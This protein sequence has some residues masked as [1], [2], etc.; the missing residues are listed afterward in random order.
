MERSNTKWRGG[1]RNIKLWNEGQ[2]RVCRKP[3]DKS[4]FSSRRQYCPQNMFLQVVWSYFDYLW[5]H[6]KQ[7]FPDNICLLDHEQ[8]ESS[9]KCWKIFLRSWRKW[10]APNQRSE[11]L[12]NHFTPKSRTYIFPLTYS[13]LYPSRLFWCESCLKLNVKVF[14][15]Q[16]PSSYS[17]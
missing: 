3:S 8:N 15:Q 14:F 7:T 6:R 4:K 17:R 2:F 13:T 5:S 16:S 12:K 9:H 1:P 11:H 10:G